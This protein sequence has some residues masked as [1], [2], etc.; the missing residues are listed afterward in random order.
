LSLELPKVQ[1][2]PCP[3]LCPSRCPQIRLVQACANSCWVLLLKPLPERS[4][5]QEFWVI[6]QG[7]S[8]DPWSLR[9]CHSGH[10]PPHSKMSSSGGRQPGEIPVESWG[11]R[12]AY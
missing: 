3:S 11:D 10:F 2:S 6:E 5:H 12:I 9:G 1:F 8:R 7:W 4:W